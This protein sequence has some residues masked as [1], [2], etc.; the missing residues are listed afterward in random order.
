MLIAQITDIHIKPEGQLAYRKVNTAESLRACVAHLNALS[1][2]PD[3]ALVSGDLTDRGAPEEYELVRPILDALAMP[4][5]VIP[6]NHDEREAF[7]Q[8]FGDH[9][10]LPRSGYL[11]Y[12]IEDLPV[13]L[14]GLDTVVAGQPHGE[15]CAERLAWLEARLGEDMDRVTLLFM[16]HPPFLTGIRHMDRQNCRNSEALGRV[17]A[18]H[19]QVQMILCG[20]VHRPIAV[21]W[22]GT[23]ALI[24]PSP[25]HAVALDLSHEGPPAFFLE[26]PACRLVQLTEENRL[27]S[28]ISY[29]G[30]YD[31]PH[32]FFD[33]DG[34][35]ID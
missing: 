4:I 8:A 18:Q 5:Y 31:G 23:T 11:N 9:A 7:R 24:G 20:H 34:A 1:P 27:V 6:G 26:P 3:V 35:L 29:I 28:H 17:V 21:S 10:Y 25:C 19:D 14:I 2:R 32:P 15:M 33:D 12:A 22:S 30:A 13:R 16:H